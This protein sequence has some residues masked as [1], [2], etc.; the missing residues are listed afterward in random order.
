MYVAVVHA[1]ANVTIDVIHRTLTSMLKEGQTHLP[2]VLNLQLDN[3]GREN[4]NRYLLAYLFMLVHLGV[5]VEVE[6]NFLMVGHTHE[7]IDQAFSRCVFYT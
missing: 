1:G 7:D 4:K 2:P 5:F 6:V 3:C